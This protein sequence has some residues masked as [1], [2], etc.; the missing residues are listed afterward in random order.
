MVSP[1]RQ[2]LI[3]RSRMLDNEPSLLIGVLDPFAQAL[4]LRRLGWIHGAAMDAVVS[5]L[6]LVEPQV[7]HA[8]G[9]GWT[10]TRVQ[11]HVA[12]AQHPSA[13]DGVAP[14]LQLLELSVLRH[15]GWGGNSR[16]SSP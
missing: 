16:K 4:L 10:I 2:A 3:R 6:G 11:R 13:F 8:V 15:L 9:T 7:M 14:L 12:D 5:A 1:P